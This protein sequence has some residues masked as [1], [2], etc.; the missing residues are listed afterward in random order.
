M[1]SFTGLLLAYEQWEKIAV[2]MQIQS[3]EEKKNPK[4]LVLR[5]RRAER[6]RGKS[7]FSTKNTPL[8]PF[9]VSVTERRNELEN[10]TW[11]EET[12]SM[13]AGDWPVTWMRNTD[14]PLRPLPCSKVSPFFSEEVTKQDRKDIKRLFKAKSLLAACPVLSVKEE[15]VLTTSSCTN[16][17]FDPF[18]GLWTSVLETGDGESCHWLPRLSPVREGS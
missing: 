2:K 10:W 9:M 13:W 17:K 1:T 5:G 12:R 11:T 14:E 6:G 16:V 8:N 15:P 3:K 7:R 18:C 4:P